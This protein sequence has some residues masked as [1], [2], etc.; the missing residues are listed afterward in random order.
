MYSVGMNSINAMYFKYMRKYLAFKGKFSFQR[1][2]KLRNWR[3]AARFHISIS[4]TFKNM[5]I[6]TNMTPM[7]VRAVIS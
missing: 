3:R 1:G 6:N 7:T 2:I 5:A 4:K